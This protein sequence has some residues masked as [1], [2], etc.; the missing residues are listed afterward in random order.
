M[1]KGSLV[2]AVAAA[3]LALAP[4][5]D[6]WP[7][8]AG[9]P[10]RLAPYGGTGSWVSI[11]DTAAWRDP[12]GVIARLSAHHVHTLY[13]ETANDR[14]R[15]DVVHPETVGRFLE[16]AHAAGID[17]VGWYLP[18]LTTA[19]RDVRRALSGIRFASASGQRFDAFALDVEATNVRSIAKR[20]RRATS[21]VA[22]IRRAAPARYPLGAITIDPAGA[23]YWPGYPFR[24]LARSVDVFLPMA[25]FTARTSG[26]RNVRTYTRRNVELIR[27]L[28]DDSRFPVH[29]IGGDTHDAPLREVRAFLAESS[30][31]D[32]LGASLWEYG[33]MTPAQWRALSVA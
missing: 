26:V 28:V 5:A 33:R 11:Y 2:A 10:D 29:P 15:V 8:G 22:A 21:I 19:R 17:V 7:I 23:R 6:A 14:Q 32:S 1:R 16:A 9:G 24:E 25:Y 27:T 18:S 30:L 12:E 13:L 3:L 4:T 20:T 31:C